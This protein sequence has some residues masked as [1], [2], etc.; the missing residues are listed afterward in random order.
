MEHIV[1][2]AIDVSELISIKRE[3]RRGSEEESL[4]WKIGNRSF[5]MIQQDNFS[6]ASSRVF[7]AC[8]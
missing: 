3:A 6:D 1:K 7:V 8:I 5:A 4:G 2:V